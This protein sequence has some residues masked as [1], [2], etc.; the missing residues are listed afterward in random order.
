MENKNTSVVV[1]SRKA[2]VGLSVI[3]SLGAA[4]YTVDLIASSYKE[5]GSTVAASSKYVRKSVEIVS[6]KAKD[7]EDAE[8]IEAL[9]K[10]AQ[11]CEGK[12]VL[13]TTDDYTTEIVDLNRSE[14]EKHYILPGV[15][16]GGNGSLCN[17][18]EREVQ[19]QAARKAGIPV[20]LEWVVSLDG[21]ITLPEDVVYP[22]FCKPFDRRKKYRKEVA[23]CEDEEEL[24]NHLKKLSRKSEERTIII[25]ELLGIETEID[26]SGVCLDQEVIIPAIIKKTNMAEAEK[27]ITLAGQIVSFDEIKEVQNEIIEMMKSFHYTG[28]FDMELYVVR[29]KIYFSRV[30]FRIGEPNYS[31]FI[32]GVNLPALYVKEV[33]GEG[34]TAEEEKVKEFGKSFIYEKAAWKDYIEGFISKDELNDYIAL[35]DFALICNED[36]PVPGN[37]FMKNVKK[38]AFRRKLGRIKR[39]IKNT[40]KKYIFPTLRNIKAVLLGLPQTKS[41]NR[42]NPDAEKP[43]VVIAGRNYGSNLCT[44]R[45]LGT[46]GYEV[47]ILRIF[48]AKPKLRNIMKM[49]KPDAY[50]QYVKAY[51]VCVTRRRS[52]RMIEKLIR[53]ADPDRKMLLLAADDYVAN[54]VD[55]YLDELT[56]Y[57]MVPNVNNT[58][59]EINRLMSKEV[60]KV[61]AKEAGLPVLNSCLIVSENGEF[62]IPETVSYPCF[63]KPN[64][65]KNGSKTKMKKCESEEELRETLTEYCEKKDIEM[66]VEDFVDI[67]REFSILGVSTKE[68]VIGPGFFGAK[69][70]GHAGRRGVALTGEVVPASMEQK[71][72]DDICQFIGTLNYEGLFDVDLIQT[73]DGKMY[74]VELNLRFGGSG[75]AITASGV[76]LPGM[77]ADY[78]LMNKPIDMN[79]VL[80]ET[81]KNFINEK[82]MIE[83]YTQ[84]YLTMAEMKQK[85]KEAEI[86]FIDNDVDK[87]PYRHFKKFFFIASLRRMAYIMKEGNPTKAE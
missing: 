21:E 78:M 31:Y 50:S 65:S 8:L 81:G 22:C 70:G 5:G 45:A 44:A 83:E 63:I 86:H 2:S 55:D 26:L 19:A 23:V 66:L 58:P 52:K 41:K 80:T 3:R 11:E 54:T 59:G 71:L 82:I 38:Q 74:F 46:A 84:A 73:A 51:H 64:I 16:E 40:I 85:M 33:S 67:Q 49:L 1:L 6:T 10:Y 69:E 77:F 25:Q 32:S 13:V 39:K 61:L 37:I 20:P 27:G 56:D 48:Q 18:M 75:Y 34:H 9:L 60:Q 53:I 12:A 76:N 24:K 4:G 7:G 15:V 14:L 17:C 57:Y 72:I 79:V 28:L 42:R 35:S 62:E 87:R 29:G 68:G 36:D 30:N 43:R 47:E